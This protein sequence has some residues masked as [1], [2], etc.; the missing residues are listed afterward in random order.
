MNNLIVENFLKQ[1]SDTS[2]INEHIPTLYS[3]ANQ[4]NHVTEMGVRWVSSTWAFLQSNANKIV[5]YDIVKDPNVEYV[6]NICKEYN[7]DFNFINADTLNVEIE[8]TDLLFIDT[9]HT[10]NQLYNEL[11]LHSNKVS[12]YIILHDTETYGMQDEPIYEHASEQIK[13][14]DINN[15][16]LVRAYRDFLLTKDGKNWEIH[17]IF[18]N[19]NGLT[20]LK[21]KKI[22]PEDFEPK[23]LPV[24]YF[25]IKNK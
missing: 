11:T 18:K 16:G 10:Y 22:I 6:E 7:I 9:L 2:D 3:Y 1:I 21:R 15:T 23:L 20:I 24:N 14:S 5:S 12:K 13:L 4:C 25:P 17:N 19:N 8:S